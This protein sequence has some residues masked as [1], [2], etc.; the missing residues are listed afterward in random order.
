MDL[1][2]RFHADTDADFKGF[3]VVASDK[4][5]VVRGKEEFSFI[6]VCERV[7]AGLSNPSNYKSVMLFNINR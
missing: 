5:R 6:C 1:K 4:Q 7:D 3:Q 2:R